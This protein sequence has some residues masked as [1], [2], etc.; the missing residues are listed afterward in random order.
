MLLK[1]YFVFFFF[2]YIF[3]IFVYLANWGNIQP[4]V[5]EFN[6]RKQC[7]SDQSGPKLSGRGCRNIQCLSD[8]RL[9]LNYLLHEKTNIW[10]SY[11]W[12]DYEQNPNGGWAGPA[13]HPDSR[14]GEGRLPGP[15]DTGLHWPA[16]R[17]V[18]HHFHQHV[19]VRNADEIKI[20]VC[21]LCALL[22]NVRTFMWLMH[23]QHIFV[24]NCQILTMMLQQFNFPTISLHSMMK[25]VR[26]TWECSLWLWL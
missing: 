3:T 9:V 19:Q 21:T 4:F 11:T 26:L 23:L 5:Y 6:D 8:S 7:L 22:W 17:L 12:N 16:W 24:R 1:G 18:H 14:E 25:Q 13:I 2:F 20:H 15:P 10:N